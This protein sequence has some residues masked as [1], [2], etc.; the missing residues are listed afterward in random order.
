VVESQR[1][2]GIVI[3]IVPAWPRFRRAM[4]A[5]SAGPPCWSRPASRSAARAPSTIRPGESA[6]SI[7][8]YH[9]PSRT[10][11]N[12]FGETVETRRQTLDE[13]GQRVWLVNRTVYD[14]L[15]RASCRPTSTWKAPASPCSGPR[16]T[17]TR[18][19]ERLIPSTA[20]ASGWNW[21]P[22]KPASPTGERTVREPTFYD[23][24]GRVAGPSPRTARQTRYEYDELG[25]QLATINH[26]LPVEQVGIGGYPAGTLVSLRSETVYDSVGQVHQQRTNLRHLTLPDGSTQIDDSDVQVTTFEYDAHGNVVKTIFPDHTFITAQYDGQGRKTA[27]TDPMGRTRHFEYDGAGRLSAVRLPEVH[28]PATGQSESPR[29]EYGYDAQGNRT[30]LRDPLGR[31]TW[32]TFDGRNRQLSRTLPLGFGPDGIRGT[33]DDPVGWDSRPDQPPADLPFTERM[34]YDQQGRQHLHVSFEG[35]V[36][37]HVYSDTDGPLDRDTVL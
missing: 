15:G 10:V 37:Q 35:V 17:T 7:D 6:G 19:A 11:Y 8:H 28:N 33:G 22:T 4:A 9:F 14:S 20:R 25:R 18:R 5:T 24:E 29:Y 16:P 26:P 12:R 32:F 21:I 1:V 34:T 36:T 3:D 13:H 2:R 23:S 31:E 27:E 30:L